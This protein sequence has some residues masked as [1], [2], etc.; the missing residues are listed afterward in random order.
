[1]TYHEKFKNLKQPLNED[2][3]QQSLSRNVPIDAQLSVFRNSLAN[4]HSYLIVADI[5]GIGHIHR[6]HIDQKEH[7][8]LQGI[9]ESVIRLINSLV[10]NGFSE[11]VKEELSKHCGAV[12][13]FLNKGSITYSKI[14]FLYYKLDQFYSSSSN[15]FKKTVAQEIKKEI[16]SLSENDLHK[17]RI[18]LSNIDDEALNELHKFISE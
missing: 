1:M 5:E 17:F 7:E 11:F 16:S 2:I 8:K 9:R 14:D 6:Y 15:T 10:S 13:E 12:S 18:L 4:L 3:K